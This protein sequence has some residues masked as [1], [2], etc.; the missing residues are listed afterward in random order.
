MAHRFYQPALVDVAVQYQ[1][2]LLNLLPVPALDGGR[3]LF[4]L[5]EGSGAP[6][7]PEKEGIFYRLCRVNGLDFAITYNDLLRW[8]FFLAGKV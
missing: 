7:D 6:L 2:S 5:V 4:I 1:F 3:L 8:I